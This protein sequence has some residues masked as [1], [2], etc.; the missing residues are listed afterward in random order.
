MVGRAVGAGL[1][2]W[3]EIERFGVRRG[4]P[5]A[6][7]GDGNGWAGRYSEWSGE[8]AAWVCFRIQMNVVDVAGAGGVFWRCRVGVGCRRGRWNGWFVGKVAGGGRAVGGVVV[9][10]EVRMVMGGGGLSVC[11]VGF[12][13]AVGDDRGF[14]QVWGGGMVGFRVHLSGVGRA[15]GVFLEVIRGRGGYGDCHGVHVHVVGCGRVAG[16]VRGRKF[17]QKGADTLSLTEVPIELC[18]VLLA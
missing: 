8:W 13:R 7:Y 11:R 10:G 3:G 15:V 17:G 2:A 5:E 4:L 12:G 9:V 1:G 18:L 6:D 16:H 14:G